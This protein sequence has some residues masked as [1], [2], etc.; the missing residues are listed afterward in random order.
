MTNLYSTTQ[1]YRVYSILDRFHEPAEPEADAI[2]LLWLKVTRIAWALIVFGHKD[3]LYI[4][5]SI[6]ILQG[7]TI[8][9]NYFYT[10]YSECA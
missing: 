8:V 7:K 3:T 1:G 2:E 10:T 9:T 6:L 5:L 4:F